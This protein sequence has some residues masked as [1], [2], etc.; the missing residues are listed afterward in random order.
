MEKIS[1][2]FRDYAQ[3][4][5]TQ[6]IKEGNCLFV[7]KYSGIKASEMDSLRQ[8]LRDTQSQLFI[9][10]NSIS[11]RILKSMGLTEI[12]NALQGPC[13]IVFGKG[14]AVGA[15]KALYNFSKTNE[16]LKIA[17]GLLQEKI[18]S[19]PEIV[20]LAKLPSKKA[21]Y[22]KLAGTLKSPV[23]SIVW[24][25]SGMIKKFVFVLDQVKQKKQAG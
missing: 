11:R 7:V 21:L 15:S 5:L 22:A 3:D 10:K 4:Y 19:T 18:L 8:D 20:A 23:N 25:L 17:A 2:I 16:N 13:G 14:D 6:N 12:S 24:T 1:K 9:I